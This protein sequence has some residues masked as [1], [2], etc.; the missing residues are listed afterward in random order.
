MFKT[1]LFSPFSPHVLC[2]T[3]FCV[4]SSQKG[5]NNGKKSYSEP[6]FNYMFYFSLDEELNFNMFFC[7]ISK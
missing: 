6:D 7:G 3:C 1:Y 2:H 5:D 4:C